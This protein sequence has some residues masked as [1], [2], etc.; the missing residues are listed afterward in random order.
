MY[1]VIQN[2]YPINFDIKHVLLCGRIYGSPLEE[3]KVVII[4]NLDLIS[5]LPVDKRMN[6]LSKCACEFNLKIV[7][8]NLLFHDFR[9]NV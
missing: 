7:D 1:E 2:L 6:D 3:T 4:F 8:A 5:K 9:N